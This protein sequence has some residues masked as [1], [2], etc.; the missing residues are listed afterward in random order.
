MREQSNGLSRG[1]DTPTA[2]LEAVNSVLDDLGVFNR[3]AYGAFE[4]RL[5]P[6]DAGKKMAAGDL[7]KTMVGGVPYDEVIDDL[8]QKREFQSISNG[9]ALLEKYAEQNRDPGDA[10][11]PWA[12]QL[13]KDSLDDYGALPAIARVAYRCGNSCLFTTSNGYVGR[14]GHR[15]E[16]GDM[17][18]IIFECSWPAILRPCADG[19]YKILTFTYIDGI[20][21]DDLMRDKSKR[22]E[23]NFILS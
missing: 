22:E 18:C 12:A 23:K 8:I 2:M 5:G 21:S 14:A 15:V 6:E 19:S 20:E 7:W 16:E 4:S 11:S 3:C 9:F 13:P 17:L 10:Q 1:V